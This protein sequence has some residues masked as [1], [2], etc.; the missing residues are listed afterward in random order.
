MWQPTS[1]GRIQ[2]NRRQQLLHEPHQGRRL[3]KSRLRCRC[4]HHGLCRLRTPP[5]AGWDVRHNC[6]RWPLSSYGINI[7]LLS[8]MDNTHHAMT[9][10]ATHSSIHN[11]LTRDRCGRRLCTALSA[12]PSLGRILKLSMS[13]LGRRRSLHTS[14]IAR[15]PDICISRA[16]RHSNTSYPTLQAIASIRHSVHPM[17]TMRHHHKLPWSVLHA[18][19][20]HAPIWAHYLEVTVVKD[21]QT[22]SRP[23]SAPSPLATQLPYSRIPLHINSHK[24]HRCKTAFMTRL[25][26]PWAHHSSP[27]TGQHARSSQTSQGCPA[28]PAHRCP[29]NALQRA[30][31][32]HPHSWAAPPS[33]WPPTPSASVN[34]ECEHLPFGSQKHLEFTLHG[35]TL[36]MQ[37]A[38]C[39]GKRT[40][41]CR[42]RSP[43][44]ALGRAEHAQHAPRS[45]ENV[46]SN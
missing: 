26:C 7:L 12:S 31:Q 39:W 35:V 25:R 9:T 20:L 23:S 3:C 8:N 14:S 16:A 10:T 42:R 37:R 46:S 24:H 33:N 6:G 29:R 5:V 21:T 11:L 18:Q 17:L 41:S 44:H 36:L 40:C 45:H 38:Q 30:C 27:N 19:Q 13:N 1:I 32:T 2:W 15:C 34:T 22:A 28:A 4:R 43:L